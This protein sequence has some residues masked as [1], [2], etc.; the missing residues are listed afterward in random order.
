MKKFNVVVKKKFIDGATG[1]TK[2][3]GDKMTISEKRYL[4]IIRKGDYVEIVKDNAN[5]PKTDVKNK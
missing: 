5:T 1:L 2:K 3:P 4:E